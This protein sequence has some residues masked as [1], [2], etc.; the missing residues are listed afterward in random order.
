MRVKI[1]FCY[2]REDEALLQGLEKQ[3]RILRR[4]GLIDIWYDRDISAGAEW[5]KEIRGQLDTSHIILFLV[6]ADFLASDYCSGV[7]VKR[8]MERHQRGEA[9]VIPVILRPALWQRAPFGQLQALPQDEKP[10]STWLD[11]DSA[12]FDIASGIQRIIEGSLGLKDYPKPVARAIS[13]CYLQLEEIPTALLGT[14][15]A[16]REGQAQHVVS[17]RGTSGWRRTFSRGDIYWSE[18]TGAH[19]VYGDIGDCYRQCQ[20]VVGRPGFPLTH[21][22]PA[23]DSPQGTKGLLQRFEGSWEYPEHITGS[24]LRYGATIY[25]SAEYGAHPTMGGV[26]QYYESLGGTG[27]MLGF[28]TSPESEVT[29]LTYGITGHRQT[30]EGGTIFWCE[31]YGSVHVEGSIAVV[32]TTS[33]GAGGRWGFPKS[34]PDRLGADHPDIRMQEFDG[35]VICIAREGVLLKEGSATGK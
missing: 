24:L 16:M 17:E 11:Q 22:L 8:A 7:E 35:G 2:A 13:D 18:R 6:S 26:G 32:Y 5:E 1:F 20:G 15:V 3:L 14:S 31:K 19:P 30:F 9:I 23:G 29:S 10:V 27:G 25:W 21:E 34:P 28:P 12:F 33:G 4:Q